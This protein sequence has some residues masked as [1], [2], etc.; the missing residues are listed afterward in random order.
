MAPGIGYPLP[1]FYFR[2]STSYFP[3]ATRLDLIELKEIEDT[4]FR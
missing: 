1:F 2:L 3:I 4:R